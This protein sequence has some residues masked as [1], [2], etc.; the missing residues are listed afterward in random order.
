ML[1]LSIKNQVTSVFQLL[2]SNYTLAV[3]YNPARNDADELVEFVND[4]A[5][6]SPRI[7][8]T[9]NKINDRDVLEFSLLKEGNDCRVKFRGIPG[10]HEFTSLLLA[11]L[12]AD[13]KGKN[14]PDETIVR[15]INAISHTVFFNHYAK[16]AADNASGV[17]KHGVAD[18][19][20]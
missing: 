19:A 8:A 17:G 15:R 2:D 6:C 10:G 7:N 12:N 18:F 3:N 4:F 5:S 11:V 16:T 9:F 14:L 20:N 1:D 13:G